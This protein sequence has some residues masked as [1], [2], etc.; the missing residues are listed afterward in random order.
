MG[1]QNV[2]GCHE[3]VIAAVTA[4]C[5]SG[6]LQSEVLASAGAQQEEWCRLEHRLTLCSRFTGRPVVAALPGSARI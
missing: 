1:L 4:A 2:L 5:W 6:S 3:K